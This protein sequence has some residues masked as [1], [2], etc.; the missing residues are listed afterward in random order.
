MTNLGNSNPTFC[1]HITIYWKVVETFSSRVYEIRPIRKI[2]ILR[3]Q[4][5][6]GYIYKNWIRIYVMIEC[7]VP[8]YIVSKNG[9]TI[10]SD[11]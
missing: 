11:V 6:A 9:Y 4:N 8:Q 5:R 2:W 7:N 3:F 10:C 1:C